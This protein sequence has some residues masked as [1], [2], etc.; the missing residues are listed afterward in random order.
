M[1]YIVVLITTPSKEEAEKIASYLVENHIVACVNIVEKVN[2]LFFWQGSI[3]KAEESLMIIK[4]KKSVFKKLIEE[5]RK[6]HSYTVP[7]IIALPII[8]GFEDY[9]K[10]IE[11]TVSCKT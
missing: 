9:L 3:E 6:M 2:S 8:D 11:E 4:T 10:W 1:E 5:V 7:E